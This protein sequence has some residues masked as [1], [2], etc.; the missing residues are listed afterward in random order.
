MTDFEQLIGRLRRST[1]VAFTGAGLSTA[2]G[3]PDYRGPEG[4]WTKNPAA[5]K[6]S[7]VSQY[8]D[9]SNLRR[10]IWHDRLTNPLYRAAP[11]PG[12]RDR[13]SVV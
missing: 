1:M 11:T 6:L 8:R 10:Q 12:H 4:V 7:R 5:A 9:D 2:A 13:K 3:I